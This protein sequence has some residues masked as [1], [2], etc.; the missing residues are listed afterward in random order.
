[1]DAQQHLPTVKKVSAFITHGDQLL[2]FRKPHHPGTG[3]QVPAG[4]IEPGETPEDAVLREAWEES[5]L[6]GFHLCGLLD[7]QVV[8]MRAYGCDELH[9]RW[10]FHLLSPSTVQR[11]WRH[12]ESCPS[13]GAEE[14]IAFDFF[15]IDVDRAAHELRAENHTALQVLSHRLVS[16]YD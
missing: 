12:G 16:G 9:D 11:A 14:F 10:Y 3:T 8:D 6:T 1:M 13:S 5:G 2:V 7:H 15:W 4:T